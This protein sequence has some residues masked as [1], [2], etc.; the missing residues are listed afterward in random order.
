MLF[1]KTNMLVIIGFQKHEFV[2]ALIKTLKDLC[3]SN[4]IIWISASK[5]K[6]GQAFFTKITEDFQV[7]KVCSNF[8][9]IL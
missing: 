5:R 1:I 4:T 8:E 2:D 3:N 6:G 7:E 9:F